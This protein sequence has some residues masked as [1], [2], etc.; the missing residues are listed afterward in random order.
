[1]EEPNLTRLF[2][3]QSPTTRQ[4][5]RALQEM[6]NGRRTSGLFN[7]RDIGNNLDQTN[8]Q[9]TGRQTQ[10]NGTNSPSALRDTNTPRQRDTPPVLR[11]TTTPRQRDTTPTLRD[12][13]SLRQRDTP[14]VLRDNNQRD[15]ATT[16]ILRD[17]TPLLPDNFP[18]L[19][20][21]NISGTDSILSTHTPSPDEAVIQAR[22]RRQIPLTYSPDV[23][24]LRQQMQRNKLAAVQQNPTSRLSLPNIRISPRKRLNLTDTP[25]SP[26]LY[27]LPTQISGI[28]PL[29]KKL[30]IESDGVDPA[31]AVRGLAHSQLVSLISDIIK[32]NPKIRDDVASLLPAPD[33]TAM[34]EPLNIHKKNIFKS[35]PNTRLESKTDS[36]AYNRVA[37]HLSAF[38]KVV[39]EGVKR[40][41]SGEQWT[42]LLDYTIIAWGYV[43]STPVWDNPSHNGTRKHCFKTLASAALTAL[44][45]GKFTVTQL[46]EVHGK[47]IKL[48]P[49]TSELEVCIK[50]MEALI[51]NN[52][53][54]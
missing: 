9:T 22:G 3:P 5:T 14:P 32:M 25:P 36:M 13:N 54:E 24:P 21:N 41:Q 17:T 26:Q 38:R 16:P 29:A 48:T 2:T 10:M 27:V 30:K 37:T 46:K 28:S 45:A 35:L 1:M 43:Q 39:N 44:K 23:T 4:T 50:H 52:L 7:L 8:N 40:L 49:K 20:D 51:Q 11:D 15:T 6:S 53:E 12:A 19:R 18:V 34:E 47:F 31:V 42:A 33:L